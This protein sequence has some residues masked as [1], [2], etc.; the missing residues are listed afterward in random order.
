MIGIPSST[1]MQVSETT[2]PAAKAATFDQEARLATPIKAMADTANITRK[3][4]KSTTPVVPES[5]VGEDSPIN[6][7]SVSKPVN[8][9]E[10]ASMIRR[11]V[12]MHVDGARSVP[13]TSHTGGDA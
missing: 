8:T 2:T 12:R 4:M 11:K 9:V 3:A 5:F 1:P 13:G 6:P 10:S 7:N